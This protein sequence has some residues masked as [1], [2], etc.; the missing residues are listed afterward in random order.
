MPCRSSTYKH[1]GALGY[2]L[3]EFGR[4]HVLRTQVA[5]TSQLQSWNQPRKR[6]IE[7]A[8]VENIKFVKM[9]Y[10]K[11]RD[12]WLPKHT[13]PVPFYS[14]ILQILKLLL[15]WH[16]WRQMLWLLLCCHVIPDPAISS[17]AQSNAIPPLP[18]TPISS[19]AKVQHIR[20]TTPQPWKDQNTMCQSC[21]ETDTIKGGHH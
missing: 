2:A 4:M 1:T 11:S 5:C 7:T 14:E 6:K 3:E 12:Q 20:R 9:E 18:P 21:E 8:E 16:N 15:L 10:G 17:L 19:I 13:T